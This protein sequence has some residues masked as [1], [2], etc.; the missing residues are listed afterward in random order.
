MVLLRLAEGWPG[1]RPAGLVL[2]AAPYWDTQGWQQEYALPS[3]FTAP[4]D[5]PVFFHHCRDD[6]TVPFEHLARYER[7]L[8][9]AAFRRHEAGGHQF[10]GRMFAVRR[11]V[12]PLRP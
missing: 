1:S 10:E 4:A 12:A 7:L 8:P 2:L 5:L 11:D 3:G 6:A 9:N